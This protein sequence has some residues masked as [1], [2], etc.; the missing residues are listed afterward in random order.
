[1]GYSDQGVLAGYSDTG[2]L[3]HAP[4]IQS[5][6]VPT[7]PAPSATETFGAPVEGLPEQVFTTHTE[8]DLAYLKD[9]DGK[10]VR[11]PVELAAQYAKQGYQSADAIEVAQ[12]KKEAPS[13][14]GTFVRKLEG[15][16]ASGLSAGLSIPTRT[17]DAWGR[18][19]DEKIAPGVSN[20]M[21]VSNPLLALLGQQNRDA[22]IEETSP[23]ALRADINSA[24]QALPEVFNGGFK[25]KF[26]EEKQKSLEASRREAEIFPTLSA[27]AQGLGQAVGAAPYAI[28]TGGGSIPASI[29]AGAAESAAWGVASEYDD[30]SLEGRP[31]EVENLINSGLI[32]GAI[33]AATFGLAAGA[34]KAFRSMKEDAGKWALGTERKAATERLAQAKKGLSEAT[35]D[36][37]KFAAK[38]EIEQA[39]WDLKTIEAM[40]KAGP[41]PIKQKEAA[42]KFVQEQLTE[43]KNALGELH[44]NDWR[45]MAHPDMSGSK[46]L[47]HA[48][49]AHTGAVDSVTN[50][51]NQFLDDSKALIDPL[52]KAKMKKEFIESNF[53]ADGDSI[54]DVFQS[55]SG[56]IK[57]VED[58]VKAL[59]NDLG[60]PTVAPREPSIGDLVASDVDS[61]GGLISGA[62]AWDEGRASALRKAYEGAT[63]E[64]ATAIAT[65][66]KLPKTIDNVKNAGQSLKPVKVSIDTTVNPPVV[67]YT[68]GNHRATIAREAGAT[69][70]LAE[71]EVLGKGANGEQEVIRQFTGAVPLVPQG[72][73]LGR[74][75][76]SAADRGPPGLLK[77]E[78]AK[79][80]FKELDF[81]IKTAKYE[82]KNANSRAE[83]YLAADKLRAMLND[84]QRFLSDSWSKATGGRL[85]QRQALEML[86]DRVLPLYKETAD[87]LGDVS[88]FGKQGAA[89]K[90]VNGEQGFVSLINS[91]RYALK[92]FVEPVAK[93]ID[94]REI[95]KATKGKVDS[96]LKN[97]LEPSGRDAEFHRVVQD[98]IN[99]LNSLKTGYTEL[100]PATLKKIDET[101]ASGKKVLDDVEIAERFSMKA[102]TFKRMMETQKAQGGMLPSRL[103][104]T[105]LAGMGAGP[106]AAAAWNIG[107]LFRAAS[108][109]GT[110]GIRGA[111][112]ELAGGPE[113]IVRWAHSIRLRN[114]AGKHNL[115][116][117]AADLL[118]YF[119]NGKA[120]NRIG[121]PKTS[122][123]KE[124][125]RNAF[126]KVA[127]TAET[128][129]KYSPPLWAVHS[130]ED[131]KKIKKE[132]AKKAGQMAQLARDPSL[133]G[134][135]PLST[136][137][138][139]SPS[140]YMKT[141]EEL[142]K[143]ANIV[144]QFMPGATRS[145]ILGQEE[146]MSAQELRTA[147]MLQ[148][149]FENPLS[150]IDDFQHGY[151]N[152]DAVEVAHLTAPNTFQM[153]RAAFV[154]LATAPD[155][156]FK[157]T[158]NQLRQVDMI[159]GFNG[160]LDGSLEDVKLALTAQ[161]KPQEQGGGQGGSRGPTKMVGAAMSQN[162]ATFSSQITQGATGGD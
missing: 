162:S 138:Y 109:L 150:I 134:D 102:N 156:E 54:P 31:V 45:R 94:G 120:A 113:Q 42:E 122:Q 20:A 81:A 67:R 100:A 104:M 49:N 6:L 82:L 16:I 154:D 92:H 70:I 38:T 74:K 143:R 2:V 125:A 25:T 142:V 85:A 118:D 91:D 97:M 119:A 123:F 93:E 14:F 61:A 84:K 114:R 90:L 121:M 128:A 39:E 68:D 115:A 65:G 59:R 107:P 141:S 133:L 101:I 47:L 58:E 34:G 72:A 48:D 158:R 99:F 19:L 15:G 40:E 111:G 103:I 71:V 145:T 135:T 159:L 33:G 4:Q 62:K 32:S 152:P 106:L 155:N 95:F 76:A 117:K 146:Q 55:V 129:A 127:Q 63:P 73:R 18:I 75:I 10:V 153:L 78:A 110:S 105:T 149:V 83:A 36:G 148:R 13:A 147:E 3:G 79:A 22:I 28:A 132:V 26:E 30:A 108:A 57:R 112:A 131:K 77:T 41:N 11:V 144:Q 157:P 24:V 89:Q 9:Q 44:P 21:A 88:I 17:Y 98:R 161:T 160:T 37:S 130:E 137:A 80:T 43:V 140:L 5:D 96:Y 1:M 87:T 29:A 27:V 139:V 151:L 136:L 35:D 12:A 64:E 86:K 60:G 126:G 50:G 7:S 66:Q 69:K 23:Q 51:L 56:V 53:A 52:R 116:L 124:T 46:V 8:G